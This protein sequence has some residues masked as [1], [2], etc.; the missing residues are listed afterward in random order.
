MLG[1]DVVVEAQT[2]PH[3]VELFVTEGGSRVL[4]TTKKVLSGVFVRSARPTSLRH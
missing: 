2:V 4:V 1:R 3:T